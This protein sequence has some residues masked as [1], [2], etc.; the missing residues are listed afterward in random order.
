MALT[1][2]HARRRTRRTPLV[3]T[4]LLVV[5][6]AAAIAAYAWARTYAPLTWSGG[7]LGPGPGI[8]A[9]AVVGDE[10]TNDVRPLYFVH[11]RRRGTVTVGFDVTNDGRFAVTIEGAVREPPA[12]ADVSPGLGVV[13]LRRAT[14]ENDPRNSST[15]RALRI[16]PH[17]SQF[18]LV[19]LWTQCSRAQLRGRD[20]GATANLD[21]IALRYRYLGIFHRTK[22]FAMPLVVANQCSGKLPPHTT[23]PY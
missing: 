21:G 9:Q 18:L 23:L 11:R 17:S 13:E 20:P 12:A 5:V 3:V 6:V 4:A 22:R 10:E 15:F 1:A 19:R 7:T 2:A 14:R 8:A 16:P